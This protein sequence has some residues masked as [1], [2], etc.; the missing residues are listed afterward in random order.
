[1]RWRN[2]MTIKT[3]QELAAQYASWFETATRG[4]DTDFIRLKTEDE[5]IKQLIRA[6]HNDMMPDDYKYQFIH[7]ALEAIADSDDI[8]EIS[9]EPDCYN[10]DLLKWVSS[11]LTRAYYVDEAVENSAYENFYSALMLGQLTEKEEVLYSVKESLEK[12]LETL[13]EDK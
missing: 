3:I 12:I 4:D 10:R 1:M 6:A 2:E 9:L 13:N 5:N 8:D 7:E 11:Y